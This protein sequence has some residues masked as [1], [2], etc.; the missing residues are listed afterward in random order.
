PQINT[1]T[2]IKNS[3]GHKIDNLYLHFDTPI[4]AASI[5]QIHPTKIMKNETHQ[6][7]AIKIIHPNIHQHF[8]HNLKNF[9]IVT[10][11]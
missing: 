9:Y 7:I 1:I 8:I 4:A 3:L 2:T 10:R 5:A 11:M 6:K